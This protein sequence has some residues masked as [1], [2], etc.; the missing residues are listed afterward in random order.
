[1]FTKNL[2]NVSAISLLP[3][4][5]F[6]TSEEMSGSLKAFPSSTSLIFVHEFTFSEKEVLLFS[7]RFICPLRHVF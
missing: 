3:E 1:M 6:S 2:L 5:T 4:I 7:K